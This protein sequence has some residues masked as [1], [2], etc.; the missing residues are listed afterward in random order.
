[1]LFTYFLE[2]SA[3]IIKRSGALALRLYAFKVLRKTLQLIKG[4]Y[5][6][7]T[8]LIDHTLTHIFTLL[9]LIINGFKNRIHSTEL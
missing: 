8:G 5:L 3:M 6:M 4:N 9:A 1:M 7:Y 2:Q